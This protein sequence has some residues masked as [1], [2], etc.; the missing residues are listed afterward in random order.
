MPFTPHP[1]GA[2]YVPDFGDI[3]TSH[4]HGDT[5]GGGG[6]SSNGNNTSITDNI[7]DG[8]DPAVLRAETFAD[9][10]DPGS[11]YFDSSSAD[12]VHAW[13]QANAIRQRVHQSVDSGTHSNPVSKELGAV[14]LD[15]VDKSVHLRHQQFMAENANA[16]VGLRRPVHVVEKERVAVEKAAAT[17]EG[18]RT[19]LGDRRD[20]VSNDA[21]HHHDPTLSHSPFHLYPR[22][23]S[24][25]TW[26]HKVRYN[27]V[28]CCLIICVIS[29]RLAL[30]RKVLQYCLKLR[31]KFAV[32]M[33]PEGSYVKVV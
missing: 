32:E 14:S 21:I 30:V 15:N 8:Q 3:S 4:F 9:V 11:I 19:A 20:R 7:L 25:Y 27:L 29:I 18:S 1:W 5:S 12:A 17:G 33:L 2:E 23:T 31:K 28:A 22:D 26:S 16:A 13:A 6:W 24:A 10:R